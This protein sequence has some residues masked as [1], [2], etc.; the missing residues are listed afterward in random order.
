MGNLTGLL[1]KIQPAIA[2]EKTET[3]RNGNNYVFVDKV[4]RQNVHWVI[5]EI[6]QKSPI[7]ETA[8]KEGAIKIVGGMYDLSTGKVDFFEV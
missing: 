7:I 6:R 8:E 2:L 5:R 4:A 3:E 1:E